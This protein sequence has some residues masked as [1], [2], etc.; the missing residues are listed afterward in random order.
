MNHVR[1]KSSSNNYQK[2]SALVLVLM[3][4]TVLFIIGTVA[5]QVSSNTREAADLEEKKTQA[6]YY[7]ESGINENINDI[8]EKINEYLEAKAADELAEFTQLTYEGAH[9][10]L[11]VTLIDEEEGEFQAVSHGFMTASD[12]LTVN[13]TITVKF[14]PQD[15]EGQDVEIDPGESSDGEEPERRLAEIFTYGVFSDGNFNISNHAKLDSYPAANQAKIRT[16]GSI[17]MSNN[18]EINGDAYFYDNYTYDNN[19]E[20][21]GEKIKTDDKISI[22]AWD[23]S[24]WKNSLISAAGSNTVTVDSFSKVNETYTN[25]VI[26]NTVDPWQANLTLNNCVIKEDLTVEQSTLNI[27]GIVW[28]EGNINFDNKTEVKGTGTIIS[29]GSIYLSNNSDLNFDHLSNIGL[30]SLAEG[31]A[32]TVENNVE[33]NG[34]LYA[35]NGMIELTNNVLVYG[36]VAGKQVNINS[37]AEVYFTD[38]SKTE[39]P[40]PGT[41]TVDHGNP[42][43]PVIAGIKVIEWNEN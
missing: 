13:K 7:A 32:I 16:N 20:I 11:A 3:V 23:P 14:K 42:N 29:S 26:N 25:A 5:L 9:Y 36:S 4:T 18:A 31:P 41:T 19:P 6:L 8:K 12:N 30:I 27:S 21:T 24:D 17:E 34:A 22:P 39:I 28:V 43:I 37:N 10:D 40:L 35:P 15:E 2:G 1:C 33:I 38:L